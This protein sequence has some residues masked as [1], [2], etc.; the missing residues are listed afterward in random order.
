MERHLPRRARAT[1]GSRRKC[2]RGTGSQ[3]PR[4]GMCLN[5]ALRMRLLRHRRRL[6]CH[7]RVSRHTRGLLLAA[8][9]NRLCSRCRR[10]RLINRRR[11]PRSRYHL[12]KVSRFRQGTPWPLFI[13][14][15]SIYHLRM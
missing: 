11:R 4:P 5:T 8:T 10:R 7:R 9:A 12:P 14:R 6:L 15:R 2:S 13:R 1:E 3:F